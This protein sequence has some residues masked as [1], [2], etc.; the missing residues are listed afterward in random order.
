M[1]FLDNGLFVGQFGTPG[2]AAVGTYPNNNPFA[3]TDYIPFYQAVPGYCGNAMSP[4][5][6]KGSDGETYLYVNDEWGYG[7]RRCKLSGLQALRE[8]QGTGSLGS[9]VTLAD[10]TPVA[11]IDPAIKNGSAESGAM[12][13]WSAFYI[14][15]SGTPAAT[16]GTGVVSDPVFA[17]HGDK[18]FKFKVSGDST[19]S[20]TQAGIFT[21]I[22][23]IDLTRGKSFTISFQVRNA[24]VNG[25]QNLITMI[26]SLNSANGV[27]S[28]VTAPT[29]PVLSTESWTAYQCKLTLPA[30]QPGFTQLQVRMQFYKD[31][32]SPASV[33]EGYLDNIQVIQRQ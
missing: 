4:V 28:Q 6:T 27:I 25:M 23:N 15:S 22:S 30:A 21:N 17:A 29:S 7:P 16:Q 32:S 8:Y 19:N 1:H 12:S 11:I 26:T 14:T 31:G 20:R 3:S 9:T 18:Y 33:Y 24:P 2:R 5:V 13:P 10:V